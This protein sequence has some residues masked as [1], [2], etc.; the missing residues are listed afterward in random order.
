LI[1]STAEEALLKRCSHFDLERNEENAM[2]ACDVI[3]LAREKQLES[4]RKEL[5]KS[6]KDGVKRE[7][8]IRSTIGTNIDES[9]F[10]EYIRVSKS[11]GAGD[12]DATKIIVELIDEAQATSSKRTEAK[13]D[14]K[15][16]SAKEKAT[17]WEHRE[18]THGIRRLTKE[19]VGRVRSLRFFTAVRDL[20]KERENPPVIDCPSCG[21]E[22]VA[23]EDAALLSSCG[24]Q[25]CKECVMRCA[26]NEECVYT[27]SGKC[28]SAARVLNVVNADTLGVDDVNRD[29]KGR[30]YGMKLEKVIELITYVCSYSNDDLYL[31]KSTAR[32]SHQRTRFLSLSN[33]TT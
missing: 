10:S 2:K 21:K 27:A 18:K 16:L 22:K 26:S 4:C 31:T 20:Q 1:S 14:Q 7:K 28:R 15:L 11:E 19:L 13:K 33:S 5:L 3:V 17:V 32:R 30:H 6:I 12:E 25:G 23:V 24:H 9:M 8:A 29:G